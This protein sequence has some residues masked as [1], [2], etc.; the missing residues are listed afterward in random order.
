MIEKGGILSKIFQKENKS[1]KKKKKKKKKK[2]TKAR[3]GFSSFFYSWVG[4]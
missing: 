3:P 2:T 1:K 4:W